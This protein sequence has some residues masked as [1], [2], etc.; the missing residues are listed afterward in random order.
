MDKF[1]SNLNVDGQKTYVVGIV[2]ILFGVFGLLL[3]KLDAQTA[4]GYITGG[5]GMI[6]LRHA[7]T[8]AT[9]TETDVPV[10]TSQAQ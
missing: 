2:T 7:I 6:T 4:F 9:A 3:H 10:V 1:L 8:T 5:L